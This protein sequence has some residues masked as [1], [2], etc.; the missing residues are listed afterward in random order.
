MVAWPQSWCETQRPKHCSCLLLTALAKAWPASGMV[1]DV[2]LSSS[3]LLLGI[4]DA[5]K[6]ELKKI[7]SKPTAEHVLYVEDFHLL[8]KVAPKLSRRLCFTASEPPRPVKQTVQGASGLS[9]YPTFH[10]LKPA[11]SQSLDVPSTP[12]RW[13]FHIPS[14][15]HKGV[16]AVGWPWRSNQLIES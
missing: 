12:L 6:N 4:K 14:A 1:F 5:D 3:F 15:H 8:T 13:T 16:I 2:L 11:P 7:A 10:L 9:L